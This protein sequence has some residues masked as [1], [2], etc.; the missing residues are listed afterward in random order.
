MMEISLYHCVNCSTVKAWYLP[1]KLKTNPAAMK[2]LFDCAVCQR[3]THH[4]PI[5]INFEL[6]RF[7][8]DNK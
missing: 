4:Y 1:N 8:G 2:A 6:K 3:E 7:E 5:A